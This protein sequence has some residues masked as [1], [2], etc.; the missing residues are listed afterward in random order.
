MAVCMRAGVQILRYTD[1]HPHQDDASP[2]PAA[3]SG[4]TL[5]HHYTGHDAEALAYGGDWRP[6]VRNPD[7]RTEPIV[8]CSFYD[9]AVHSWS[10]ELL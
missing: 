9:K 7:D 2:L 4:P 3:P 1:L 10:F 6:G 8:S 5:L